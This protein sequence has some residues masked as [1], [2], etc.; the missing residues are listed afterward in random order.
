MAKKQNIELQRLQYEGVALELGLA[1]LTTNEQVRAIILAA[2]DVQSEICKQADTIKIDNYQVIKD[3]YPD[4]PITQGMFIELVNLRTMQLYADLS[5]KVKDKIMASYVGQKTF[6]ATRQ[7]IIDSM[8]TKGSIQIPDIE[9]EPSIEFE[10]T[11][12]DE[13]F[14]EML[15]ECAG[16]RQTIDTVLWPKLHGYG[17]A[18][19]YLTGEDPRTFKTLLDM[20]HYRNG[21]WPKPTTPPRFWSIINGFVRTYDTL[22]KYGFE[23][24]DAWCKRFGLKVERTLQSPTLDMFGDEMAEKFGR[25]LMF[26][27]KDECLDKYPNVQPYHH[28]ID[29]NGTTLFYIW[30]T[31][32]IEVTM[33]TS[34]ISLADVHTNYK[35]NCMYLLT[36]D[37][38][39]AALDTNIIGIPEC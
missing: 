31:R 19:C 15:N 4:L 34:E 36:E 13:D 38:D 39:I 17:D 10:T 23:M 16:I 32:V 37:A 27:I 33:P 25:H 6:A 21:G 30:D 2:D 35:D 29:I 9:E 28:A 1:G 3:A 14:I 8:T 26:K 12:A 7:A 5:D 20:W 24:G 11:D 22:S 18:F